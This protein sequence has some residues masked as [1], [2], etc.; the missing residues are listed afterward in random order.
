[1]QSSRT[2][3]EIMNFSIQDVADAQEL[4]SKPQDVLLQTIVRYSTS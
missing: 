1:M 4:A 2:R 3:P